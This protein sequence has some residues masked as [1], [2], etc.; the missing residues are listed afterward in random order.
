MKKELF[1]HIGYPKTATTTLQEYLFS[2]H[3][4]LIDISPDEIN[5][6]LDC[7]YDLLISRENKVRRNL[8]IYTNELQKLINNKDYSNKKV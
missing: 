4:E 7:I 5:K 8:D 3:S 2:K 6:R 1:L